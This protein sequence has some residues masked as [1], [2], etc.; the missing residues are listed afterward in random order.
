M[1]V[2]IFAVLLIASVTASAADRPAKIRALMQAEGLVQSYGE[3]LRFGK[4][5]SRK[6]AQQVLDQMLAD[7]DPSPEYVR[8]FKEAYEQF[9]K[10]MEWPWSAEDV[11]NVWAKYYGEQFTDEELDQLVAFYTS[12]LGKKDIVATQKALPEFNNH[13]AE[14]SKPVVERA[15]K[16]YK[17][18]LQAIAKECNCNKK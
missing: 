12:P 1:R 16:A 7:L 13:F 6:Q 3:Q 10:A 9:T 15:T 11:V 8:R 14:L 17:E 4:E 5:Q 2:V 18:R